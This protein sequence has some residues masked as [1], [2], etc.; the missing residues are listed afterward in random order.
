MTTTAQKGGERVDPRFRRIS[1]KATKVVVDKRFQGMFEDEQFVAPVRMDKYG[2]RLGADRGKRE[3][4]RFYRLDEEDLER[5]ADEEDEKDGDL[6]RDNIGSKVKVPAAM[7]RLEV[8]SDSDSDAASPSL[9]L[10]DT[11]E[12]SEDSGDSEESQ[13]SEE[14]NVIDEALSSHPLVIRNVPMGEA[15]RRLA[16]VNMDWDQITADDIY[17]LVYGFKPLTGSIETV[18]IYPSRFGK[19]RMVRENLEGPPR[20]LFDDEKRRTGSNYSE[21][22][23][24]GHGRESLPGGRN[25][26]QSKRGNEHNQNGTKADSESEA[27]AET[28]PEPGTET[29]GEADEDGVNS[30]AL[31]RYQLERLRY[32]YAVIECDSVETARHIY[33]HCDGSEFEKSANF[34]D[35]RF[36][37]DS[38]T[39][40]PDEDG[41]I[42]DVATGLPKNYRSK[43]DLYTAALQSTRVALTWDADDTERARVMRRTPLNGEEQEEADLRAYLAS[44]S[45]ASSSDEDE[46]NSGRGENHQGNFNLIEKYRSLLKEPA[47]SV[48][49]RKGETKDLSIT[50]ASALRARED[51]DED[52]KENAKEEDSTSEIDQEVTFGVEGEDGDCSSLATDKTPFERYLERRK[53]KRQARREAAKAAKEATVLERRQRRKGKSVEERQAEDAERQRL[54]LLLSDAD[55]ENDDE[56]LTRKQAK[57]MADEVDLEDE[58]FAA[59]YEE[60]E[61]ALD[62]SHPAFKRNKSTEKIIKERQRRRQNTERK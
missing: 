37:P 38:V 10:T 56:D 62:P 5:K 41:P 44:A 50:F 25:R 32:Y 29:E 35:L 12:D 16:L 9:A 2:R 57:R 28:E 6:R 22:D 61:Y 42:K 55:N 17:I 4:E 21:D 14:D 27:E 31:R 53:A 26:Y 52:E 59:I 60:S 49:G 3:L 30:R 24:N 19:E 8:Q 13:E 40:S 7:T 54:S 33:Q 1:K 51:Q 45:S 18:T 36:I 48:F 11:E 47:A 43:P 34:L 20:E 15:T 39:F 46:G 58:R 23:D